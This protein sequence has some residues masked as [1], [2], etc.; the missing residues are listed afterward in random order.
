MKIFSIN[1]NLHYNDEENATRMCL[2][3]G[4]WAERADYDQ[5]KALNLPIQIPIEVGAKK[6]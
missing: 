1:T 5:C 2:S 3:N 4:T 6:I